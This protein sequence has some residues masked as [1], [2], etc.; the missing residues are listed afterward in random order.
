MEKDHVV[1]T[2]LIKNCKI[3]Q[4]LQLHALLQPI[5]VY[6]VEVS[7]KNHPSVIFNSTKRERERERERE[8]KEK[9][10][11]TRQRK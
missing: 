9:A 4:L 8:R 3:N 2:K 1:F 7:E 10:R 5:Y 6:I 11:A